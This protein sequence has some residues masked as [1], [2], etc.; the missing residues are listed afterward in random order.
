MKTKNLIFFLIAVFTLGMFTACGDDDENTT[1]E[2]TPLTS[3]EKAAQ[4]N[5]MVGHYTG[6]LGYDAQYNYYAGGLVYNDTVKDVQLDITAS[7]STLT[8]KNFPLKVFA[9]SASDT[10]LKAVLY[11]D[12]TVTMKV[13]LALYKPYYTSSSLTNYYY[14]ETIP[15]DASSDNT[16][17]S[18][19]NIEAGDKTYAVEIDFAQAFTI[20]GSYLYSS[21]A[22]YN[23]EL[24]FFLLT[25]SISINGASYNFNQIIHFYGSK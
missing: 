18:T 19:F 23:D 11:S 17:T 14:Y 4:M 22:Y 8:F 10:T 1:T 2:Y 5:A 13:R 12:T 25:K 20:A 7:D 24:S 16:W 9:F 3:A 15:L 6:T 21:G